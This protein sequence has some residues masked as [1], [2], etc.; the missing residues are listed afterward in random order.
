[1]RFSL[2]AALS[3]SDNVTASNFAD[4]VDLIADWQAT[5]RL[6]FSGTGGCN[7]Q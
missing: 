6:S 4:E 2:M 5:E 3:K 1:M 7:T